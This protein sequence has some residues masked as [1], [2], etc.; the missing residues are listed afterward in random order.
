MQAL[1]HGWSSHEVFDR[2][3]R[4]PLGRDFNTDASFRDMTRPRVLTTKGK[5]VA[6]LKLDEK[7][8]SAPPA[9]KR[10]SVTANG[11]SGKRAKR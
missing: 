1:P 10:A 6:P 11:A 9:G 8:A 5:V 4:V 2:A 7:M 3:L